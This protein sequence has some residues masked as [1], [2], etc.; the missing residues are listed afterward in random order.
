VPDWVQINVIPDW[1]MGEFEDMYGVSSEF[2]GS[3][4]VSAFG[5]SSWYDISAKTH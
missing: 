3:D 4:G 5:L 1:V 2:L